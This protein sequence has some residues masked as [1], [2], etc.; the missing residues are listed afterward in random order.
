MEILLVRHGEVHNPQQVYYGRLPNFRL[1]DNGR[2]QA[3]AAAEALSD[4]P[5]DALFSSPQ[6]RAQETAGFITARKPQL[7]L[8]THHLLNEVYSPWDG[9]AHSVMEQRSY[10]LY[11]DSPSPY[12]QPADIVRRAREFMAW[13]RREHSGERI[14]AVTHGD[15]IA[16]TILWAKGVPL[17]HSERHFQRFDFP[18]QYP[19][20]A[21]ITTLTFNSSDV[22]EVPQ[23]AYLRP[24]EA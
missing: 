14:A 20:T 3:Q 8:Q 22:T 18:D 13:A 11:T 7:T 23:V 6:P 10:D 9:T 12:E 5:L 24:Y 1:S 17:H 16:F 15:V 4:V 2:R 19:A 21:S